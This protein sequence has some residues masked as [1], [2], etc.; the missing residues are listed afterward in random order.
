MLAMSAVTTRTE[1]ESEAQKWNRI[2]ASGFFLGVG[3]GIGWTMAIMT[4]VD[5][6]GPTRR[7]FAAGCA[8]RSGTRAWHFLR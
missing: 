5:V 7:G 1:N 4:S 8:R 6:S 3:Q 2:V